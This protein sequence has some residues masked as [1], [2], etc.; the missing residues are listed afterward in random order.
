MD[1]DKD[2]E[3]S[4]ANAGPSRQ[5]R[6]FAVARV[7]HRHHGALPSPTVTRT[8]V[9]RGSFGDI[10]RDLTAYS[11][12]IAA[13]ATRLFA[14]PEM[15]DDLMASLN[16]SFVEMYTL[17]N[18]R[19]KAQFDKDREALESELATAHKEV[20]RLSGERQQALQDRSDALTSLAEEQGNARTLA[21]ELEQAR[22]Q[23]DVL[24]HQME[25]AQR[26]H[27]GEVQRLQ[28]DLIAANR[29]IEAKDV[30]VEELRREV[31]EAKDR[32]RGEREMAERYRQQVADTQKRAQDDLAAL[33][34]TMTAAVADADRRAGEAQA[35]LEA[36]TNRIADAEAQ[37]TKAIERATK[38]ETL[39]EARDAT[40]QSQKDLITD[41]TAQL[42][43]ETEQP[44]DPGSSQL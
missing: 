26:A 39:V 27:T 19:A 34:S 20:T 7:W 6:V 22:Q 13:R 35:R 24:Y 29:L 2:I 38:A 36:I 18:E 16:E 11:E 37:R 31:V 14:A 10:G 28:S 9:G 3:R 30:A 44:R 15:P 8:Y 43:R 12:Q 42:K 32:A 41:L 23:I 33:R 40:I 1:I 25:E 17:L 5:E 4:L 21:A